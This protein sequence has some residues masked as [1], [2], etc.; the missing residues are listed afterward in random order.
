MKRSLVP[1]LAVVLVALVVG[2]VIGLGTPSNAAIVNGEALPSSQVNDDLAAISASQGYRCYLNAVAYVRTSGSSGLG[3]IS[4]ATPS[5]YSSSF[6]ANWLDQEITD[7][8]VTQAN[9]RATSISPAELSAAR[10]DLIGSMDSTLSQVASTQYACRTNA[11]S[12]LGSMPSSFVDR[13]VAAQAQSESLIVRGGGTSLDTSS[14]LH[15]FVAHASSF[16]SICVSGILAADKATAA[17]LRAQLVAGADFASVAAASSLDTGSKANGGALG[18]FAPGTSNYQSVQTDVGS[19]ASGQISQPLPSQQGQYVLLT[20]T[21][22]TPTAFPSI[23]S[24]VRRVVL[25]ADAAKS[26]GSATRLLRR[27]EVT[28]NPLYGAWQRQLGGIGVIPPM[29]P[30]ASLVPAP[31]LNQPGASNVTGG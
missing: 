9:G 28:V 1:V 11:A 23:E 12:I 18:C 10:A 27:A 16:D 20:V 31:L 5:S 3:S 4:G 19:L 14:L 6:V 15:Y 8:L 26:Q 2:I 30:Q 13:Q 22:R 7:V 25:A 29:A 21:K 17:A 24:Y